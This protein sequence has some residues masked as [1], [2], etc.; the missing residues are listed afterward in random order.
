M[1]TGEDAEGQFNRIAE[2]FRQEPGVTVGTGFGSN[3]GLRVNGKIFAMVS[4]GRL[5][6]KLPKERV[7]ELVAAGVAER[8]D[9]GKGRPMR[10]WAAIPPEGHRRWKALVAE[11]FDFARGGSASPRT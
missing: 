9:A 5:V 11:A 1:P 3:P 2:R 6:T 4:R 7:D 10:E 8:F